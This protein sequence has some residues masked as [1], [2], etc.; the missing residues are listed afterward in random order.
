MDWHAI[1]SNQADYPADTHISGRWVMEAEPRAGALDEIALS[2]PSSAS[3]RWLAS[4]KVAVITAI[5]A[6]AITFIEACERY[7][8]SYE[9]LSDWEAAFDQD[10]MAGLQLKYRSAR[11]K[12]RG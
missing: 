7:R 1:Y 2:L 11:S 4:N 8:L 10:G 5:R 6:G 12:Q 3:I 9:E